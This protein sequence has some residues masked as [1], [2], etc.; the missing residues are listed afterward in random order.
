MEGKGVVI[1]KY[2]CGS[3]FSFEIIGL[4]WIG[5]KVCL[6]FPYYLTEKPKQTI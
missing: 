2:L 4:G 1:S 3:K 6:S 5:P